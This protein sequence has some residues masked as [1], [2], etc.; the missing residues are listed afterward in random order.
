ML[1]LN[2]FGQNS[3]LIESP[4]VDKRVE[5]ISIVFRL[6]G[7][8]EYSAEEIKPYTGKITQHFT[9]YKNHELIQ[10]ARKMRNESSISFDAP[11]SLA[12]FLDDNL[13]PLKE[14]TDNSLD[15][16]KKEDAIEFVKLLKRFYIEADCDSFFNDNQA[17]YDEAV[18]RFTSVY[19]HL[20]LNWYTKF[21][22]NE[23]TEKFKVVIALGNGGSCYGPSIVDPNGHKEVYA[24]MGVW[25]MDDQGMPIF[26]V[27]TYLSILI[28]E[29]NHSFVNPLLEKNKDIFQKNGEEIF[30]A[31]KQE[32]NAQAYGN[33][34]TV[35]NEALVR[36]SVIKY[37]KDH[38][39]D[40][41]TIENLY[42]T[43]LQYGFLWIRELVAE[44]E[45]YDLNRTAYP[46]L[47]SYMPKLA[48]AYHIY[49]DIVGQYDSKRPKVSSIKEFENNDT[50]V[51][52]D[53]KT[54]TIHF[55]RPLK[56]AGYSIHLGTKGK[57]AFPQIEA[58]NYSTDNESIVMN[59][60]LEP[61]KEY[62]FILT[63]KNF[64]TPEGFPLKTYEVN[65][66]TKE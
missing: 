18:S 43:E 10:F 11:M 9:P 56:G 34:E 22:G 54:I 25:D 46:I 12:I 35:L 62:Q 66:K 5:L 57:E 13:D 19:E 41:A 26:D 44:L 37:Y 20:D 16:W 4:K 32:M 17:L 23:P 47:E 49:A 8:E 6:A 21:Y 53:I 61:G 60:H 52:A 51:D 29:F 3:Q 30:E 31:M 33:W 50:E 28:H 65:F 42:K 14:L 7:N 45:K 63:G 24:V 27:D 59:V 1:S 39:A 48:E 15:R 58:I 64:K 40:Q 38:H 2:V 36:A 55:D